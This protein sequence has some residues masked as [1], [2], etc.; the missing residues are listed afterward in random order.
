MDDTDE[1]AKR[2]DNF[3][4]GL[5]IAQIEGLSQFKKGKKQL[6][7]VSTNLLKRATIPQIKEKLKL[8]GTIGTD[9]FWESS[10]LLS[11]E[12]VR[13]ELRYLI[14]FIVDEGERK[15]IY[16]NLDDEIL[17]VKRAKRLVAVTTLL[18]LL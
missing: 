12:K 1:Q 2:F 6:I 10:D 8:I 7:D 18:G 11:F 9:E 3:M 5:M 13:V 14:K 4:H 15:P 16:T 17:T